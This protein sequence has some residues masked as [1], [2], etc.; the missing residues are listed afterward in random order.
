MIAINSIALVVER[1]ERRR[2]R[3]LGKADDQVVDYA[4]GIRSH[5]CLAGLERP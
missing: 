5:I 3:I 2:S 4:V 1:K